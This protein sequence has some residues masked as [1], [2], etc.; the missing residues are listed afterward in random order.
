M[1]VFADEDMKQDQETAEQFFLR[2]GYY[3]SWYSAYG[4][5]SYAAP[6]AAPY[7]YSAAVRV[8]DMLH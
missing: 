2:Y 8:F 4:L 6:Y 1:C 7:A 5:R 3:P